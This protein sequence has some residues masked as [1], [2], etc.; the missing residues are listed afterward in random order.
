MFMKYQ[1]L[2]K[3]QFEELHQE[4]I[5]FL[6][7]QSIT[8]EEWQK[9]KEE[10]PKVAE[11]ELDVF[12]DLIWE[13]VLQ[14]VNYVEHMSSNKFYLFFFDDEEI[15][16]IVLATETIDMT[17]KEGF[18]WMMNHINDNQV[19]LYTASN[20]YSADKQLD[21]FKLI[22]QGAVITNGELYKTLAEVLSK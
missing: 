5:R 17:T 9:I 1:R 10:Q 7:T 19:S 16:L 13:G 8:K 14:K 15:H 3:E 22:Q 12:S 6:A 21:K 2:S 11:D 4:F 20:N 18:S